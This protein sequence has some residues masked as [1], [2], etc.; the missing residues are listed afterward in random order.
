MIAALMSCSSEYVSKLGKSRTNIYLSYD[1]ANLILTKLDSRQHTVFAQTYQKK[2]GS[3]DN[4]HRFYMNLNEENWA[5]G[6]K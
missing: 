1:L 2:I 6:T 4:P 3:A 5:A